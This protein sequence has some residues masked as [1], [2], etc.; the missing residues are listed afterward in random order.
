[1]ADIFVGNLSGEVMAQDLRQEF[2]A[3]GEVREVSI[4]LDRR[5]RQSRG[6][7]FVKM[8]L[9]TEARA[10][11]AA[12]NRKELCGRRMRVVYAGSEVGT[13]AALLGK[14]DP[15][16]EEWGCRAQW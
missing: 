6:F 1:M 8:A 3:F 14:A 7:G 15:E 9:E 12:L 10:A 4:I 13:T 2:Q 11:A 5:T 16:F